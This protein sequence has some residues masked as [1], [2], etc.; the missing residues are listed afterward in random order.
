MLFWFLAVLKLQHLKASPALPHHLLSNARLSEYTITLLPS[1]PWLKNSFS[2]YC[3]G[4]GASEPSHWICWAK[5]KNWRLEIFLTCPSMH[6]VTR[7]AEHLACMT[8]HWR[9]QLL[10]QY[11]VE[12][13]VSQERVTWCYLSGSVNR[14]ASMKLWPESAHDQVLVD[15]YPP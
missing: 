14:L 3:S 1:A 6:T 15:F 10:W 5:E 4:F 9:A 7:L 2:R 13:P 11:S 12:F 8:A